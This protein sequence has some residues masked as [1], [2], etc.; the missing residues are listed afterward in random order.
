MRG[1]DDKKN[2]VINSGYIKQ[3][4]AEKKLREEVEWFELAY[5]WVAA[6]PCE[7]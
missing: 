6:N 4:N 3:I 2:A 5:K 1:E 7:N